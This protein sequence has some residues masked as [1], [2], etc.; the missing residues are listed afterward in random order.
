[1]SEL[2]EVRCIICN[3]P[4]F[5]EEENAPAHYICSDCAQKDKETDIW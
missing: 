1:M 3:E 2:I 4:E 5:F